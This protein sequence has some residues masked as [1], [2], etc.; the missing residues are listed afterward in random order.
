MNGILYPKLSAGFF[1]DPRNRGIVD[2]ADTRE[3]VMLDLEVQ[4]PSQPCNPAAFSGEIHR[5]FHLMNRPV[6]LDPTRAIIGQRKIRVFHT[7]RQLKH[8]AECDALH[9]G[10]YE[11]TVQHR[12][13]AAK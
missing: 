8:N 2:V 13:D 12:P 4:S 9:K 11:I 7:V 5:R 6:V 10:R 3:Q 1:D